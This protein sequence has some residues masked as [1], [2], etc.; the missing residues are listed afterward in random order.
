MAW[1]IPI[2]LAASAFSCWRWSF[3]AEDFIVASC[4][5]GLSLF[6]LIIALGYSL[7]LLVTG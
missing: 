6:L 7:A 2:I 5:W 4:R 3:K 1:L